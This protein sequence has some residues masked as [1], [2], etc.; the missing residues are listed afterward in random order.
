METEKIRFYIDESSSPY[1]NN[2]EIIKRT[3]DDDE[4]DEMIIKKY[5]LTPKE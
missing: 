2:E 5:N 4:F 3:K 1:E